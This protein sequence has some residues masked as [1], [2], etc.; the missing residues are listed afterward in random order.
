MMLR[1]TIVV[2]A[3]TLATAMAGVLLI[4]PQA[5]AHNAEFRA[6][7]RDPS[8]RVVGTV[9][10]SITRH[11]TQVDARLRPNQNVAPNQ[12]HGF[13][14]HAN[15]DPANGEGC[16]ADPT[17]EPST[18][19]LSADGHLSAEMQ[20]HGEHQGD[21]PSPLVMSD[22]TARLSFA[23]DRIEPSM[24]RGR[25]VVLHANPDNFGNV[26]TGTGP[27]QYTPGPA[28]T[29]LTNRTGNAGD[30]VACGVVRRAY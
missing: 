5:T 18:W 10:F 26:P 9:Q 4:G 11:A 29:D 12:F 23:T 30:R 3:A 27:T 28:A 15:N 8:G 25:A 2:G 20:E 21:L 13:H 7:L 19:F 16:V 6:K 24:L 22:G 1:R 17:A 14:I